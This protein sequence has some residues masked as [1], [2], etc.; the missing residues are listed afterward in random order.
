M[1][2]SLHIGWLV[3][4]CGYLDGAGQVEL[5]KLPSRNFSTEISQQIHMQLAN[6]SPHLLIVSKN[7]RAQ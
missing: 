3:M 6:K 7:K 4:E 1:H 2:G 5:G